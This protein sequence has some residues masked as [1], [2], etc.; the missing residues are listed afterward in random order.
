M[1]EAIPEYSFLHLLERVKRYGEQ[2]WQSYN[3]KRIYTWDRLHGEVEVYNARGRHLG[4]LDPVSGRQIKPA[5]PGR[6]IDV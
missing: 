5:V 6:K 4:V 3:G 1:G 2:R